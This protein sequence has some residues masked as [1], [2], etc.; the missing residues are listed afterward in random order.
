MPFLDKFPD[1]VDEYLNYLD[2]FAIR[3]TAAPDTPIDNAKHT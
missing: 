1:P 3:Q 2:R